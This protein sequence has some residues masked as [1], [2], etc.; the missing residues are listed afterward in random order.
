MT[1]PENFIENLAST[2]VR[3]LTVNKDDIS[4]W[5]DFIRKVRAQIPPSNLDLCNLLDAITRLLLG[6][7]PDT[8]KVKFY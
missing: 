8:I 1:E 3:V 5:F 6:D 7:A 2:T 4:G